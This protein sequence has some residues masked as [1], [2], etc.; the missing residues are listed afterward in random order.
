MILETRHLTIG[1]APPRRAPIVIT[2]DLNVTLAAG[3]L[4]ALIGPNGAG[5]S[6]LI[7]T[8]TGMQTPLDGSICLLGDDL[9]TLKPR[10]LAQRVAVVLTERPSAPNLTGYA[11]V[12]LGRQPHTDW[13]GALSP[14]D[15]HIVRDAVRAVGAEDI[16]PRL[17]AELSDGQQQKLLIAR[18]LA[19][20]TPLI[21]LDEPTAYLDLPRRVEVTRLLGRLARDTGRTVLLSTHDLDLALRTADRIWLMSRD[22]G[23]VTGAPEDLVLAGAFQ[24]AFAADDVNFD[25]ATGAFVLTSDP[26]GVLA[27]DSDGESLAAIWTRRAL[28]RAGFRI[29]ADSGARVSIS[30][31]DDARIWT[32]SGA[33]GSGTFTT[34]GAL[35]TAL[36]AEHTT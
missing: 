28:E 24:A 29:K 1:Y 18:A 12:A 33:H 2:E 27:V 31:A 6:T 4:V 36:N 10:T 9:R 16:A 5:K 11:L 17:L 20:E 22:H 13:T 15:E 23:L 26:R 30:G 35:V 32:L 34:I 21:V 14:D 7:R 8:V 25:P 19:Q 3:E